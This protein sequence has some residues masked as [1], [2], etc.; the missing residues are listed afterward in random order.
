MQYPSR[1]RG[2]LLPPQ[3]YYNTDFTDFGNFFYIFPALKKLKQELCGVLN[4]H[5][6]V[7]S[8][9]GDMRVN[10]IGSL[11]FGKDSGI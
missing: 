6:A 8:E 7:E 2:I 3:V 4:A 1:L 9:A 10:Q 5:Q 11:S